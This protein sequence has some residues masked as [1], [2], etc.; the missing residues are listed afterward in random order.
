MEIAKGKRLSVANQVNSSSSVAR[1]LR[2]T[3]N[4]NASNVFQ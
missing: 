1:I 3:F 4:Y 2:L